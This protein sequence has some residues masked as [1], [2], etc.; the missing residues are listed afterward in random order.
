MGYDRVELK[1]NDVYATRFTY[2]TVSERENGQSAYARLDHGGDHIIESKPLTGAVNA[3]GLQNQKYF[4]QG[5]TM[6]AVKG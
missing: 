1:G 5:I 3:G 2:T 4:T 6:G